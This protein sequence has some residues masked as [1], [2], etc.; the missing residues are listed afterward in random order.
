[1]RVPLRSVFAR[2][3]FCDHKMIHQMLLTF[4]MFKKCK[5][6]HHLKKEGDI[7]TLMFYN[8]FWFHCNSLSREE[9]WCGGSRWKAGKESYLLIKIGR[10]TVN[11]HKKTQQ[12]QSRAGSMDWKGLGE[13]GYVSIIERVGKGQLWHITRLWINEKELYGLINQTIG[14][15]VAWRGGLLDRAAY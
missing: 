3:F 15:G 1:M 8:S 4:R 2:V 9:E 7:R 5:G 6:Y 10:L 11:G 12:W 14:G 13:L